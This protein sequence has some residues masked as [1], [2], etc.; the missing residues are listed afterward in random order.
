MGYD[1]VDAKAYAFLAGVDID[2]YLYRGTWSKLPIQNDIS[3][4]ET[5]SFQSLPSWL[6]LS[7]Q[8]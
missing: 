3:P 2:I 5:L 4:E 7:K 8:E 6:Y 1:N